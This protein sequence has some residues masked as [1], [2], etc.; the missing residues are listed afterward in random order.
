MIKKLIGL[1]LLIVL[2]LYIFILNNASSSTKEHKTEVKY[3]ISALDKLPPDVIQAL[4][5][6]EESEHILNRGFVV[7]DY[8]AVT[9]K[10]ILNLYQSISSAG[11]PF[12]N[13]DLLDRFLTP[14]KVQEIR[15][16]KKSIKVHGKVKEVFQ[17]TIQGHGTVSSSKLATPEDLTADQL[18]A[19]KEIFESFSS[20]INDR[21]SKLYIEMPLRDKENNLVVDSS[22]NFRTVEI[23]IFLKNKDGTPI[24]FFINGEVK[25]YEQDKKN[26]QYLA[27]QY[28][29]N[30]VTHPGFFAIDI[31]D[32]QGFKSRNIAVAGM[33]KDLEVHT[34]AY[35]EENAS[36]TA[37]IAD[38][39]STWA[40]PEIS[41]L[42]FTPAP[43]RLGVYL[44]KKV[45]LNAESFGF[46]PS[47]AISEIFPYLRKRISHLGYIGDGH[48]LD[49]QR[50]LSYDAI[51]DCGAETTAQRKE[52]FTQAAKDYDVF[53]T[54]SDF[55]AAR[56]A[57]ELGL[58]LIIYDPLT[59][60]WKQIPEIVG[61]ADLYVAQNFFGVAERIQS[62]P[63][64]FPEH[65]IVPPIVSG[66]YNAKKFTNQQNLL[67][68]MG[69][70]SNPYTS[71]QDLQDFAKTVFCFA[72]NVLAPAYDAT[73]YV[74][75][76]SIVDSV[77]SICPATTLLPYQ[78]QDC[79]SASQLAIMTSGLGNIYE[80]ASMNKK[81]VWLPPANDSQGQQIKL[82]QQHG[83]AD[84]FIDWA[85]IFVDDQPI[86]YFD[87]QELVMKQIAVYMKRLSKEPR[88]KARFITLLCDS[89]EKSQTQSSAKLG[90]L[91]TTFSVHGAKQTAE[92][93]LQSL[94]AKYP[95]REM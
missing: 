48:T 3:L 62:E 49:L 71:P 55:E 60:Y 15:L 31:T 56:W 33:P 23:D 64:A 61:N 38:Q 88:A 12:G 19:M 86:D 22:G 80:A 14:G 39:F 45:L 91:T 92:A 83:M 78:V 42:I 43:E 94:T 89:Y 52:K 65:A 46:G 69:G 6:G 93:I 77:Q 36:I 44:N 84:Y 57:R 87:T 18:I 8:L 2:G 90:K 58:A 40:S 1:C 70:L 7:Q 74:S 79:L 41:Q 72:H 76:R 95:P 54:A 32:Q 5:V 50:K 27:S 9:R 28:R 30:S 13:E 11:I 17:I 67:V 63:G 68:N 10:N 37:Q 34:S 25:F 4:I 75:S 59:W 66:I 81:V 29:L 53:I 26:A 82:L 85:D 21:V 24:P 73:T 20:E 51:Y 35:F 16:M 47:A